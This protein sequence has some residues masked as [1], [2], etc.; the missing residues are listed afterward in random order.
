MLYIP[1]QAR[2]ASLPFFPLGSKQMEPRHILQAEL[3][4]PKDE[5]NRHYNIWMSMKMR[6]ELIG[7]YL[8]CSFILC[9]PGSSQ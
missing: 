5:I 2:H 6:E 7:H 3:N 9:K 4:E 8:S 1:I